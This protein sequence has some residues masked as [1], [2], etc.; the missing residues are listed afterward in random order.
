[1]PVDEPDPAHPLE[2]EWF[3]GGM[4]TAH[5]RGRW[6]ANLAGGGGWKTKLGSGRIG[7]T[8]SL[9]EPDSEPYNAV[10]VRTHVGV[11]LR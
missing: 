11:T 3:F 8:N 9:V 5:G 1:M 7:S 2:A 10:P 4:C 6:S